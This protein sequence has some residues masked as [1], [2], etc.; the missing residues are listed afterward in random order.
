MEHKLTAEQLAILE[1]GTASKDSIMVNALAGCAKSTTLEALAKVLPVGPACSL[2]F[3]V[4][5]KE[6]LARR[7]PSHFDVLTLNGL[8]HRAWAKAIGKSLKVEP[9]KIANLISI[10]TKEQNLRLNSDDWDS[11]RRLIASAMNAGLVPQRY[12]SAKKG[13]VPDTDASWLEIADA[14]WISVTTAMI[15]LA[16][17]ILTRNIQQ[18]YQGLVSFDD[19]IYCSAILD[20]AFPQWPLVFIDEAQ[21]LSPLNH[22][23][24][25]KCSSNRIVAVGDPFQAIYAFRGADSASMAKIKALRDAWIELPLTTTFRCPRKVVALCASHAVGFN[26]AAS[27]PDGTIIDFPAQEAKAW[28]W[29]DIEEIASAIPKPSPLIA[30]LCRNNAP[31]LS[32]AFKLLTRGI[33][34]HM[35]G[36]DI[37]KNLIALLGKICKDPGTSAERCSILIEDWRSHESG[38]AS[39]NKQDAKVDSI[40]DRADSLIAVLT[41]AGCKDAG[42]LKLALQNLF[43]K[44]AGKVSLATGH[45][46]K[47]LEWDLVIHLDS[48]RIPSK[49]AT[50]AAAQGSFAQL[51]Q[52]KNLEYVIN[53]RTK[54]TLVFADLEN[55]K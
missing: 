30:I 39:A 15:D 18:A 55:F 5:I 44:D 6:E 24:L 1:A 47:G 41:G 35:L 17:E 36:R 51:R 40:N 11:L 53:T 42:E 21:D 26:A 16:R 23:M 19:Q 54:H 14:N 20:G 22:I 38:L 28:S 49:F 50:K 3:N 8:G 25:S 32:M 37:G 52:E 43:S 10:V 31:L 48:F 12:E 34:P 29:H 27:N 13:L 9:K 2:A 7:L 46:A 4:K 45:K 33:A